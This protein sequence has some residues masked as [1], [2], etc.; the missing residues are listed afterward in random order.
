MRFAL[1]FVTQLTSIGETF[2]GG[3]GRPSGPPP[4]AQTGGPPPSFTSGIPLEQVAV[5]MLLHAAVA[6]VCIV[7]LT[8]LPR[9][10][11]PRP[12]E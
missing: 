4:G 9:V 7:L 11:R 12:S 6:I 1:R 2:Q 5:L 10:T 3:G 8:T